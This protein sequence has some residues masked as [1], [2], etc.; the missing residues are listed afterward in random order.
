M[1]VIYPY[2]NACFECTISTFP[3]QVT[4]PM[5]TI[6][7]T[8]RLPEHCIEYAKVLQW[9]EQRPDDELDLDN[10][11]H[12][13]WLFEHAQARANEFNIPGVTYRMTQGVAKNIIPAIA[14]TN[15]TI[16]AQSAMEAFKVVS[17]AWDCLKN[18]MILN[19]VTGIYTYTYEYDRE[20]DCIVCGGKAARVKCSLSWTLGRFIE[21]LGEDKQFEMRNPSIRTAEKTLRMVKPPSLEES[22]RK[23]L[24]LTLASLGVQHGE[25]LTVTDP[26]FPRPIT[27]LVVADATE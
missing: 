9:P 19:Q 14:S 11:E 10:P 5:C 3:P 17:G 26:A 6:A 4:F 24:T 20:P 16:A 1:R 15:A 21:A 7:S 27:L 13:Q 25:H 22:T 18:N 8:P 2:M 23:N 12:I